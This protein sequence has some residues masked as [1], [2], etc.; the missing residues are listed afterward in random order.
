MGSDRSILRAAALEAGLVVFGVV[1]ALAANE[2][3][4]NRAAS[5][6]AA[7]AL[8][9][10]LEELG[11]NRAAVQ[12]SSEYHAGLLRRIG[13]TQDPGQRMT[14]RDFSSGFISAAEV[15]RTAWDSAAA[16]G[17]AA[18]FDLSLTLSLSEVYGAQ[19][20]YE[21]QAENMAR[22]LYAE[23]Y[24]AGPSSIVDNAPNLASLIG[25]MQYR[26]RQLLQMYDSALPE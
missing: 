5:R 11:R 9:A 14:L 17:S 22:I 18:N 13:K 4:E 16:T 7:R 8:D 1:L 25:A 6:E 3:R 23:L 26:E 15:Q 20:R 19:D 21:R 24:R 12:E 10:V 2:W